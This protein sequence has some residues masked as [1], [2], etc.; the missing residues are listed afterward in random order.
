MTKNQI[1]YA[2]HLEQGRHN[3]ATEKQAVDDLQERKRNA[4][5]MESQGRRRLDEDERSHRANESI[6]WYDASTR[7]EAAHNNYK[8]GVMNVGLGY[9]NLGELSRHN[10]AGEAETNRANMAD[11]SERNRHNVAFEDINRT[12]NTLDYMAK[13][14]AN[15]IDRGNLYLNKDKFGHQSKVDW[16]NVANNFAKTAVDGFKA[17]K[18]SRR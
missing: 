1:D 16:F 9:S 4:L 10:M 7:R 12:G 3:Q 14:E 6:N 11:E 2:K 15:S 8:L 17:F 5:E 13:S 18:P